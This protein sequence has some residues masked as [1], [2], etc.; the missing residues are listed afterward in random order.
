MGVRL[1]PS[2]VWAILRRVWHRAHTSAI[3][4]DVGR[5]RRAQ[6]TTMLAWDFFTLDTVLLRRLY[7]VFFIEIDTPRIYLI[8]ITAKAVGEW[9]TPGSQSELRPG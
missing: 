1:A 3:R 7:V 5:V 8:A 9:V 4:P 2:S 6:A